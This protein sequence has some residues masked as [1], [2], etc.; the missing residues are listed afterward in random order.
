MLPQSVNSMLNLFSDTTSDNVKLL[1][2]WNSFTVT[3]EFLEQ[4]QNYQYYDV[5]EGQRW[6]QIAQEL[7]N[8]REMWWILPLINEIEDPFAIHFNHNVDS[9][10]KKIKYL[11]PTALSYLMITIRKKRVEMER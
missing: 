3:K 1:D 9:S 7:Y 11:D 10:I 8:D 5:K 2:I 6:D 4:Q